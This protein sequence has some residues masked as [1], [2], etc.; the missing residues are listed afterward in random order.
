VVVVEAEQ[1]SVTQEQVAEAAAQV[2]AMAE[3]QDPTRHHQYQEL[4]ALRE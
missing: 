2:V 4:A 3:H 1:I